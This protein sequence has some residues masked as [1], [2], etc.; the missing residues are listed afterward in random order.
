M[1]SR[2]GSGWRGR[3][4]L[5]SMVSR[6]VNELAR[7]FDSENFAVIPAA[8]GCHNMAAFADPKTESDK[9]KLTGPMMVACQ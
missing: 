2:L 5:P 8:R 1:G 3:R 7:M 4:H 6:T 9:V